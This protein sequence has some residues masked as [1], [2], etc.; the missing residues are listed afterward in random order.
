MDNDDQYKL[1]DDP[2]EPE[3][4]EEEPVHEQPTRSNTKLAAPLP[5]IWKLEPE[6]EPDQP[7]AKKVKTDRAT[8]AAKPRKSEKVELGET[9]ALETYEG[10][11]RVRMAIGAVG[12]LGVFLVGMMI[13]RAV[14]GSDAPPNPSGDD[15][16][17]ELPAAVKPIAKGEEEAKLLLGQAK[18]VS[19]TGKPDQVMALLLKVIKDYP[20]TLAA[21]DAKAA[22]ARAEQELPLFPEGATLVATPVEPAP[23][24]VANP[25]T[26]V[27]A[28]A[29]ASPGASNVNVTLPV[30]AAEPGRTPSPGSNP[31][32]PALNANA[33]PLPEGY[34]PR[35][36]TPVHASGWPIQITGD[37]DGATMNF[38]AGTTFSMG[39]DDGP[40]SEAP[41]HPVT[42]SSY[43][44]DQHEVTNRQYALFLKE[45]GRR[46]ELTG[47]DDY[48]VVKV[49]AKDAKSYA[50][51]AGKKIPT[52]AQWELA[53]RSPD[54]RVYPAG[55]EP[56]TWAKPRQPRQVDAVMS[57]ENDQSPYGI[58][59]LAGN[60]WEWTNDWFDAKYY[61]T[62]RGQTASNPPGPPASRAKPPLITVRGGSKTWQT[63]WRDGVSAN[64]KLP[65]LSFRCVLPVD[66][67]GTP[68][69]NATSP[70]GQTAPVNANGVV[71]F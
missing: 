63:T 55:S 37:R 19:K 42:L 25:T 17:V 34:R 24:P 51:W 8:P 31:G 21:K 44:I 13:F 68:A 58:F 20:A 29:P 6:P 61:Q 70:G 69:P 11:T 57:F 50:D 65:Y 16:A 64:S 35:P 71:P 62:L 59:D 48:P 49:D 7:K 10:R 27:I 40:L 15:L 41:A 18:H 66:A 46:A 43:Y 30:N 54:G 39:R 23:T 32:D 56:P 26:V 36:G 38:I 22:L 47:S 28:S 53:A 52:E 3:S 4:A 12:T 45:T 60:A 14:T 33:K 9:P 1:V 5:R 2:N 67:S